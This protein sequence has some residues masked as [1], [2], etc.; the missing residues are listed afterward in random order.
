MNRIKNFLKSERGDAE[1][2]EA[3]ILYP[4]TFMVI[5]L[6]IYIGLYILQ[7][8]TVSAYAQKV[9]L[10][11]AREVASPGYSTLLESSRYST[12][13][14]EADFSLEKDTENKGKYTGKIHLDNKASSAKTRAYRYWGDNALN[15]DDA[16]YYKKVLEDLVKYNS[17]I[18]GGEGKSINAEISCRNY[19]ISQFIDVKVTQQLM[20]FP[21]LEYFGIQNP[22]VVGTATATVSDT[23]ELVRNVDFATDAI[24]ALARHF[25]IDIN[26]VRDKVGTI[27]KDLGLIN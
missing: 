7:M 4:V 25:G 8:M 5:F 23:D 10:L 1:V 14:A 26:T 16:K 18:S 12:S 13:V 15:Q 9:A 24:D 20:R 3:A 2:I 11:A 27:A 6:L 17:I 22:T 21:V 19:F